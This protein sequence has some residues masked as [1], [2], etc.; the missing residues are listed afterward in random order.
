M[1]MPPTHEVWP[2]AS[3]RLSPFCST[4][5]VQSSF[6]DDEHAIVATKKVTSAR[7][8]ARMVSGTSKEYSRLRSCAPP[9]INSLDH[10]VVAIDHSVV[11]R[12]RSSRRPQEDP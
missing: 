4:T 7:E 1:M 3:V 6:D 9:R 12:A 10:S 2:Q 5:Q 11:R 8:A